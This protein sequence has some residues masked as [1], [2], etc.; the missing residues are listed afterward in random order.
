[1]TESNPLED[2]DITPTSKP[3]DKKTPWY[4][5]KAFKIGS[6]ILGTISIILIVLFNQQIGNLLNSLFLKAAR[7]FKTI[8]LNNFITSPDSGL[9]Y[10]NGR[11]KL[12]PPNVAQSK[13]HI[14][15]IDNPANYNGDDILNIA[16]QGVDIINWTTTLGGRMTPYRSNTDENG[17]YSLSQVQK[18]LINDLYTQAGEKIFWI[19]ISL[20]HID[21]IFPSYGLDPYVEVAKATKAF[22]DYFI[23]QGWDD[24][25]VGVYTGVSND[26]IT[27]ITRHGLYQDEAIFWLHYPPEGWAEAHPGQIWDWHDQYAGA[28]DARKKVKAASIANGTWSKML[29]LIAGGD[30]SH[31]YNVDSNDLTCGS[32]EFTGKKLSSPTGTL[33]SYQL[34]VD[35]NSYF[36]HHTHPPDDYGDGEHEIPVSTSRNLVYDGLRM[37]DPIWQARWWNPPACSNGCK[38]LV[39]TDNLFVTGSIGS[40]VFNATGKTIFGIQ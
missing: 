22:T 19:G 28:E 5:T 33:C 30:S 8:T 24:T 4:T 27:N 6:I 32:G 17:T 16:K 38:S 1:M 13:R 35:Q 10:E 39:P 9:V 12:S 23:D 20:G 2:L 31:R 7:Q 11:L 26:D 34:T 29:W 36:A 14:L 3:I 40:R 18:D 21:D 25:K 15:I 37:I